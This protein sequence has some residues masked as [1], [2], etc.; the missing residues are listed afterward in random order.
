MKIAF[1]YSN[2]GLGTIDGSSPNLGNPGVGGTQ[3]CYLMLMYYLSAT[4]EKWNISAYVFEETTLPPNIKQ[5]K[6]YNIQ[7]ALKDASEK[8]VDYFIATHNNF[9]DNNI[10]HFV[11]T[12]DLKVIVWGHNYYF[13]PLANNIAQAA[14]IVANVF[15]GK[16]QYDRYIDHP[17]IDKSVT[18]FNM[19]ND[20]DKSANRNNDSTTVIYIGSLVPSKG[21]HLLAK[22]W[23][24][25]LNTHPS[26]K[27]KV[28]GTGKVYNRNTRL[29]TL[30]VADADYEK[31]FLPY[32]IDEK[33]N[34][35]DSVEFLGLLG[36]EKLAVF[37]NASV[38][39][40]NP[41]A[42]TETFGISILDM[43]AA[44]LPVV[45]LNA[46]GFPDTIINKKT[47]FL[48]SSQSDI[49]KKIVLLLKDR[50]LN[51]QL[52]TNAKKYIENFSPEIITKEW[53]NLF[54]ALTANKP[55]NYVKPSKPYSNNMKWLRIINRFFRNALK[56]NF[57]PPIIN[58]ETFVYSI[59]KK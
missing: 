15:V 43:A 41:S 18:I 56:F 46:N 35:L 21:F 33:G 47:G 58:V 59:I 29:G 13:A 12:L 48:C 3:F 23:K 10:C 6:I 42:K 52:G 26:A 4:K 11:D 25:I 53:V 17:I 54:E 24:E 34:L 2:K 38:G 57:L 30:D 31:Q 16:Q 1:L 7:D 37:L 36:A 19:I 28:I 39:V 14:N 27:L 49:K 20:P 5:I 8:L 55:I 45:T 22:M 32:I 40:V 51:E 9:M 50:H 44:K